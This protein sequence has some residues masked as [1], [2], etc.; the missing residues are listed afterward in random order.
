MGIKQI[1]GLVFGLSL[2]VGVQAK[3]WQSENTWNEEWET[4]YSQWIR[5]SF[6]EDVFTSGKYAGISTDCADAVY[7]ARVIFSAENKLPFVIGGA[8]SETSKFD[9]IKSDVTRLK[10][11]INYVGDVTST[12]TLPNDTYPIAINPQSMQPGV[13][14]LR[15]S[16]ASENFLV[17]LFAGPSAPTGHTEVIKDISPA[18]AIYLMGSTVPGKV[19]NLL[20]ST[21][22]VYYPANEKLGFRRWIWPQDRSRPKNELNNYSLEQFAMGLPDVSSARGK[23]TD[24][25]TSPGQKNVNDFTSQVQS[26]LAVRAET[27][28]EY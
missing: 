27:K 6:N 15:M 1:Y 10:A 13:I 24:L 23:E 11:F 3:V 16:I 25:P 8:N 22:L 9:Y 14:W 2:S 26:R 18:G 28:D 20:T 19:R 7:A 21:S 17:R 12:Q 5:N 4:Q